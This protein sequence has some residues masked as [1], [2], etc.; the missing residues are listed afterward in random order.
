MFDPLA[1]ARR[2][3]DIPSPT[4]HEAAVGTFLREELTRLGYDTRTQHAT[5]DR[6]NVFAGA[7]GRPRVVL[8]SHIDTVPPWFA[9]SEDDDFL[10]GRGACDT[11]GVIAAM[12]GA[13]ERLRAGGFTDFAFLFVVGEETDSSHSR[14]WD[15]STSSSGSRRSRPS[16]APRRAR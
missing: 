7:G 8:N 9:G 2:L 1:L 14:T 3:I 16:H 12:I 11:K 10:Y 13:G 6:F 4:E 15:P 5:R